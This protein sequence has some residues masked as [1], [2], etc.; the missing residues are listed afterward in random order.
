MRLQNSAAAVRRGAETMFL[1][2]GKAQTPWQEGR[3]LSAGRGKWLSLPGRT[4]LLHQPAK[5]VEYMT[6]KTMLLDMIFPGLMLL[7][8]LAFGGIYRQGRLYIRRGEGEPGPMP[9]ESWPEVALVI[10]VAGATP[11]LAANLRSRLTQDYPNYTVIFAVRSAADPAVAVINSLLPQ[12]PSARLVVC[13]PAA[14]CGQK[15]HNLLRSISAVGP[16]VAILVTADANQ[17]APPH[18]LRALVRP[19]LNGEAEVA[20]GFHHIV[21]LDHHLATL[22]RLVT[23]LLIYLGKGMS[24][25]DQPWGG[26]T[27]I[28]R[29]TW[30]R[31]RVAELWA[32][33]VVDDVTLAKR[34]QAAG[35]PMAAAA[36][37]V[38]HTPA[39]ETLGSWA[40]WLSR[41]WLY[42]KFYFP[43]PWAL[44]GLGTLLLLGLVLMA[45]GQ[46]VLAGI[47]GLA[48]PGALASAGFLLGLA[49]F[50]LAL[51][52][53]HPHPGPWP[54]FLA[55]AFLTLALAAWCHARTWG[56]RTLAWHRLVYTVDR[57]GRVAAIH[58]V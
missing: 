46:V 16:K 39:Q 5:V 17:T 36:G 12:F 2:D 33:T 34:L 35:V 45:L 9:G 22:G 20:S 7:V 38:L 43:L 53:L 13:G 31:L 48:G 52:R 42:L 56:R 29:Q 19:I 25:W 57:Q 1:L 41:Q 40:A 4:P 58:E 11:Q 3:E 15:N 10:P 14:D 18:W 51:R 37:A 30:E 21:P 8:L 32:Q 6:T 44:A 26:A 49:G 55:A 23:V 50:F 28:R 27:A 24:A 47:N 54:S